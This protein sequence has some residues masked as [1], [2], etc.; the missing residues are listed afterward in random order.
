[1]G[2]RLSTNGTLC[3]PSARIALSRR[4]LNRVVLLTVAVRSGRTTIWMSR[5]SLWAGEL[6]SGSFVA[7]VG[8]AGPGCAIADAKSRVNAPTALATN[9]ILR[10][11]IE[12]ITYPPLQD[13]LCC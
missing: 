8:V 2:L 1:M 4:I 5:E 10:I 3:C 9:P 7:G 12:P 11:E 6:R 13:L